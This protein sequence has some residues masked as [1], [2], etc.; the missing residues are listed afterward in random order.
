MMHMQRPL[1]EELAQSGAEV[2]GVR[3]RPARLWL[4]RQ[5]KSQVHVVSRKAQCLLKRSCLRSYPAYTF[6]HATSMVRRD[7]GVNKLYCFETW[8]QQLLDFMESFVG[9]EPV[10]II[11]NSV[12][13]TFPARHYGA[14]TLVLSAIG[15]LFKASVHSR[16]Q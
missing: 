3:H 9:Q 14:K 7:L 11:C 13:G 1:A 16:L 10:F 6:R 2:P 15:L 8:S 12:G 5:A 4:Q